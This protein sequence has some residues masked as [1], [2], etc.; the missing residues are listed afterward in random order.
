MR[1]YMQE[2]YLVMEVEDTGNGMDEDEVELLNH[3]MNYVQID[4]IRQ[5][6]HVG[7]LNACL[8]LKMATKGRVSFEMESEKGIGT[9]LVIRIPESAVLRKNDK[10]GN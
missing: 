5:K 3:R 9:F 10:E 7:V 8:R 4:D 1:A 6:R 2:N